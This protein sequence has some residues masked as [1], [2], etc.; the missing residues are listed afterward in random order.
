[1]HLRPWVS[2][3]PME[4]ALPLAPGRGLRSGSSKGRAQPAL[5]PQPSFLGG[6]GFTQAQVLGR[7]KLPRALLKGRARETVTCSPNPSLAP[8]FEDNTPQTTTESLLRLFPV[9]GPG[10]SRPV[11]PGGSG[12]SG[13]DAQTLGAPSVPALPEIKDSL[14]GGKSGYMSCLGCHQDSE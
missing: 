2:Q 10:P 12:P 6:M 8:C 3:V 9:P 4:P 14:H 7:H 11:C 5:A 1:M 13:A